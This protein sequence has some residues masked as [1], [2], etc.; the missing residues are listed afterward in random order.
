MGGACCVEYRS[1]KGYLVVCD[2]KFSFEIGRL[3]ESERETRATS[4]LI[5]ARSVACLVFGLS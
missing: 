2:I 1:R 3:D 4:S 5:D